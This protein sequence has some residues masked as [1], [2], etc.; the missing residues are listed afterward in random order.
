[1]VLIRYIPVH[2]PPVAVAAIGLNESFTRIAVARTDGALEM[3]NQYMRQPHSTPGEGECP[4]FFGLVCVNAGF[5]GATARGLFWCLRPSSGG[6]GVQTY[7]E[8]SVELIVLATLSG[9]FLVFQAKNLLLCDVVTPPGTCGFYSVAQSPLMEREEVFK[10]KKSSIQTRVFAAACEDGSVRVFAEDISFSLLAIGSKHP[11]ATAALS[12]CFS[13]SYDYLLVG[14]NFGCVQKFELEHLSPFPTSTSR[15]LR[16][17]SSYLLRIPRRRDNARIPA[18]LCLCCAS[19]SPHALAG[20]DTGDIFVLS[21]TMNCVLSHFHVSKAALLCAALA[22]RNVMVFGGVARDL[23]TLEYADGGWSVGQR[24]RRIHCNDIKLL[25]SPPWGAHRRDHLLKSARATRDF[26]VFSGG[27]DGEIYFASNEKNFRALFTHS[28][29]ELKA[30]V[31]KSW[32]YTHPSQMYDIGYFPDRSVLLLGCGQH[33]LYLWSLTSEQQWQPQLLAHFST[34]KLYEN[35]SAV[36]LSADATLLA[37]ATESSLQLLDL[38]GS[39]SSQVCVR[40]LPSQES[41][42]WEAEVKHVTCMIFKLNLGKHKRWFLVVGTRKG[43][44]WKVI[45]D[46]KKVKKL[47]HGTSSIAQ[48]VARQNLL[49]ILDIS[50]SLRIWDFK[51]SIFLLKDFSSLTQTHEVHQSPGSSAVSPADA[52]FAICFITLFQ[53]SDPIKTSR[54]KHKE[55]SAL[56][57]ATLTLEGKLRLYHLQNPDQGKL[58]YTRYP[59]SPPGMTQGNPMNNFVTM[60]EGPNNGFVEDHVLPPSIPFLIV[61]GTE[62]M[63]KIEPD[64]FHHRPSPSHG[65]TSQINES[66][67]KGK[68]VGKMDETSIGCVLESL[69][70]QRCVMILPVFSQKRKL[71]REKRR[72]PDLVALTRRP[73]ESLAGMTVYNAKRYGT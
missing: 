49:G 14:D 25:V 64:R 70:L 32:G 72:N 68:S 58:L 63:V 5:K 71:G 65:A 11:N 66:G 6:T 39:S 20:T 43:E 40:Q 29:L 34:K 38:E 60:N 55:P 23:I 67:D 45:L 28:F 73:L 17:N 41:N 13:P 15:R 12:I 35:I 37:Y 57:L 54:R 33:A 48:L 52:I 1:M 30:N 51:A 42:M 18:V 16:L 2:R 24:T 61:Y 4:P 46:N 7:F 69:P 10:K 31:L 22:G 27:A 62:G 3:W 21:L 47:Y 53:K 59:P 56:A 19:D 44:V 36:A 26:W 8:E 50:G 9:Q